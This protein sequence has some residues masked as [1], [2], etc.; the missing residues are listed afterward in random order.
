MNKRIICLLLSLIMLLSVVL[1]GCAKKTDDDIKEDITEEAS[2][3]TV[4]LT[5]YLMSET[6]VSDEQANKI[7]EEVNKITKSRFKAKLILNYF[8]EAEYNKALEEAFEK[9][10]D[11][12]EA[13]KA[14]E[15]ALKQAIKEGK[16]TAATTSEET[17]AEETIVNEYGVMLCT[18]YK[19]G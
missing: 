12:R 11:E 5:M 1:S 18:K 16:A 17:T 14:A 2:R 3:N 15:K 19:G 7:E 9:T 4:T 10:E 8:T 6:E 13:K